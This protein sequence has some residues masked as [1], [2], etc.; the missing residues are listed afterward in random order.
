MLQEEASRSR[1]SFQYKKPR[2]RRIGRIIA[3][4][5]L[6]VLLAV[7]LVGGIGVGIRLLNPTS[8]RTT[9]EM[10]AFNLGTGVQPTVIIKDNEG[11]VHVQSGNGNTVA[12]TTTKTGDGYGASPDDFKVNYSQNGNTITIQVNNNS[13]HLFDFSSASQA[14]INVT[15][16][17]N[18]NLNLENDS[19]DIAVAGIHGKMTLTSNSGSIQATGVSLQSGSQLLTDS[20]NVSMQ[21][22][23]GTNGH[24]AFQSNSGNVDVTLPQSPGFYVDMETNSGSITND[25]SG[26]ITQQPGNTNHTVK[27]DVGNSPQATVSLQSDSG[28]LHLRQQ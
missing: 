15:V 21:G 5:V 13:I 2:R 22:S 3:I 16:P 27:G 26:V 7:L 24:Y 17:V 25:F 11:Y 10:H 18:S 1:D 28:Y 6:V 12:V 9:T 23:I 14:D 19:G 4:V 20:G 8:I